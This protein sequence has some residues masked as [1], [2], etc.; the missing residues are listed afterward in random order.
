MKTDPILNKAALLAK[1]K[2]YEGA[3]KLLKDE[4]DRY[5]GSFKYCQLYGIISLHSGNFLEAHEYLQYAKRHKFKDV[6]VLLGLAV[7]FLKRLNT[8]QAVDYYLDILE[9]DPKNKI[10]K[11]ALNIIRKQNSTQ[12][13]SDWMTP[14]RLAKLY[15]PIP[16]SIINQQT[17]LSGVLILSIAA[18]LIFGVLFAVKAIPNPFKKQT[19]R[20]AAEFYLTTQDKKE[21]VETGGYYRYILTNSQAIALYERALS[22]F[23]NYRD[24]EM[25][26]SV[27]R[28]LESNASHNLKNKARLLLENTEI[29]G[30]DTLRRESI[31]SYSTVKNEPVIYRDVHIIWRGMATNVEITNDF[32]RFDFLI[33]YDTRKTLEGIVPVIFY[34]PVSINTERPLEVLGKIVV[35]SSYTDFS[36][37]GVAI[38]Q[39]GRLEN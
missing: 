1:K 15:P 11:K 23:T 4:E 39:S 34:N 27:N 13:L 22:L 6:S 10:A 32:T 24:E 16:A 25:K 18:I 31:P 2:D 36:L 38:Y 37:E 3:F 30:F 14:E 28:I 7:L 29:P 12:E 33:G 20:P 35:S 21:P 17:I 26:V 8:V 9:E 5:N 19:D